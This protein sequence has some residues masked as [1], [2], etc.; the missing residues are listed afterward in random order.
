MITGSAPPFAGTERPAG[1]FHPQDCG[2]DR[3]SAR[4]TV[5]VVQ[6][7]DR[8][9]EDLLVQAAEKKRLEKSCASPT[10]SRCRCCPRVRRMPGLSVTALVPASGRRLLRFLPL[11]DHR[12]GV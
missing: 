5:G 3:R 12:V 1:R 7:D 2:E 6:L 4:R 8:D 10:K 11:D 9:I